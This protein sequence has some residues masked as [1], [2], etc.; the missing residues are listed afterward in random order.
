[1]PFIDQIQF[2]FQEKPE[3]LKH[4]PFQ[5]IPMVQRTLRVSKDLMVCGMPEYREDSSS[6]GREDSE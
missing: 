2:F 6:I 5:M 4:S 3:I 1:M